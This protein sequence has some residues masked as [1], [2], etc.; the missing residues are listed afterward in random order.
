MKRRTL[1]DEANNEDYYYESVNG[2]VWHEVERED[3]E[4]MDMEDRISELEHDIMVLVLRL[5]GEDEATFAPETRKV[6]LKWK[7]RAL[8]ELDNV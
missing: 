4:D 2:R 3:P 6:M 8:E 1:H 7:D 5:I